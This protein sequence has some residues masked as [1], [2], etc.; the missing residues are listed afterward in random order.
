M[1]GIYDKYVIT[2]GWRVAA[3]ARFGKEC[4]RCRRKLK[5]RSEVYLAHCRQETGKPHRFGAFL[6]CRR[7]AEEHVQDYIFL[8]YLSYVGGVSK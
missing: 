4:E 5:E 1:S 6:L 3:Q 8:S 2:H 7:C